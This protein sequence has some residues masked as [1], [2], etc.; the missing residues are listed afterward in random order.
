MSAGCCDEFNRF[1]PT[2]WRVTSLTGHRAHAV[3]MPQNDQQTIPQDT[4]GT[5]EQSRFQYS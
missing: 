4:C 2:V 5:Q 3:K 1:S